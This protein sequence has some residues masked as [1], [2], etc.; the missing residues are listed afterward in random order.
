VLESDPVVHSRG[1]NVDFCD[2]KCLYASF[3]KEEA[4]DGGRSC[5]TFAALYCSKKKTYVHKNMPCREKVP[6]K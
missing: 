4:V 1:K 3:P 5:R 6:K 2:L